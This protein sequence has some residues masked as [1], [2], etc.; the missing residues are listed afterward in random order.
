MT[1]YESA[2]CRHCGRM[3]GSMI[4]N[5]AKLVGEY[6]TVLCQDC[7]N[8]FEVYMRDHPSFIAINNLTNLA[9]LLLARTS[10]DGVDRTSELNELIE[11]RRAL[12]RTLYAISEAW[13]TKRD[14]DQS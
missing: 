13:V 8:L 10:G 6:N 12:T 3:T 2:D 7:L 11:E 14:S 4:I 9:Q 1:K 5:T